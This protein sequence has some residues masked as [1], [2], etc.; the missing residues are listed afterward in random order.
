MSINDYSQIV[1]RLEAAEAGLASARTEIARLH[2]RRGRNRHMMANLLVASTVVAVSAAMQSTRTDAQA[3][4][5]PL[6]VRAPFEV[7][8]ATG[9]TIIKVE[10]TDSIGDRGLRV[11]NAGGKEVARLLAQPGGGNMGVDAEGDNGGAVMFVDGKGPALRLLGLDNKYVVNI[12][13]GLGMIKAP[14]AIYAEDKPIVEMRKEAVAI[15][16]AMTVADTAGRPIIKVHDGAGSS[17]RGITLRDLR[18]QTAAEMVLSP[19]GKGTLFALDGKRIAG[20][21]FSPAGDGH[22]ILQGSD[23]N[24]IAEIKKD[25]TQIN[26]PVVVGDQTA[27]PIFKVHGKGPEGRGAFLF[28]D[29]GKLAAGMAGDQTGGVIRVFNASEVAV[30]GL[31]ASAN[32]GG[33]ALTGPTGG[34]SAVSLSVGATGGRVQV[35]PAAGGPA[36]AELTADAAGGGVTLYTKAGE[37]AAVLY[38]RTT[39]AGQLEIN[40]NGEK[41][42]EAGVNANGIGL[43]LVGPGGTAASIP[44]VPD[45]YIIGRKPK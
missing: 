15:N 24:M 6:K 16:A 14:V 39:G 41:L 2:G 10:D 18:D 4:P 45:S 22:L 32:G 43:V 19:S 11:F 26:T 31:L 5:Q 12:S 42:V 1:H 36:Q 34:K 23:G 3:Q 27:K 7:V 9:R 17:S 44:G 28:T 25:L 13:E 33:L 40:K 38:A 30:G 20:V 21:G 37:P 8:D 35:F 29:T